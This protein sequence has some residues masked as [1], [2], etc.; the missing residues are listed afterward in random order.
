[1]IS[2]REWLARRRELVT[3]S[4][5]AAILGADE[6]RSAYSVW[7]AKVDENLEFVDTADMA[8]GRRFEAVIGE[9]YAIQ[10]GRP[11]YPKADP[12]EIAVHPDHPWLGATHDMWTQRPYLDRPDDRGPLQIKMAIGSARDWRE[13][14]PT[15]YQVQVQI[16]IA[17]ARASWGALCALVGPG[18]LK[19][20]DL[21]R[22]DAFLRLAIPKLEE[23]HWRV[24]NRI[25]PEV[26]GS[27]STAAA[28]RALYEIDDGSTAELGPVGQGLADSWDAH[29]L[30]L[31]S[32][33]EQVNAA[34]NGLRALV[35]EAS[36]GRLPDGSYL[37]L[38]ANKLGHRGFRRFWPTRRSL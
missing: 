19:V 5:C 9:E 24:R 11:I 3:A 26:D 25:A 13:G 36:F 33:Q 10:T 6:R 18:P 1:V 21:E 38:K 29:E 34:K 7:A 15:A 28:L 2:R 12:Y 35:G 17:C 23:F 14:P 8:R 20:F 22:D 30:L 37:S 27:D 4:D 16:E 32:E 31:E